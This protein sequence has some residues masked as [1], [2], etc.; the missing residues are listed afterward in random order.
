VDEKTER[1]KHRR[2]SVRIPIKSAEDVQSGP[3]GLPLETSNISA[4]GMFFQLPADRA[5]QLNTSV[6]F[7]LAVPPGS[8]Y[9][10]AGGKIKGA[11]EV[12]RTRHLDENTVGV[13]VQF[14]QPL[15]LEF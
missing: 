4:G 10:A 9:S 11:G 2:A 3:W 5:P 15:A 13:A 7:E 1:R 12:V 14:S 6:R 8:G